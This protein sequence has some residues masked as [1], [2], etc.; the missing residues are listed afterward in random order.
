MRAVAHAHQDRPDLQPAGLHLQD[1]AHAP[2]A[3]VDW[4]RPAR[5][6]RPAAGV[7]EAAPRSSGR[8]RCRHASRPRRRNRIPL[9]R[10]SRAPR[11]S[12]MPRLSLSRLPNCA[13]NTARSWA[14]PRSGAHGAPRRWPSRRSARRRLGMDMGVGDEQ[15]PVLQDHQAERADRMG[16]KRPR[17][18]HLADIVQVPQVLAERA[19]DQAVRLVAVTMTAPMAVVLVRMIARAR[20]G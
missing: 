1:V 6:R 15:R 5:W 7:G 14:R 3:S 17:P 2:A 8:A 10:G 18:E 13:A 19:A 20:S 16:M 9:R 11:A 4:R 12:A